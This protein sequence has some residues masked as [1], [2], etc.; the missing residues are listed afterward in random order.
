MAALRAAPRWRTTRERR[1]RAPVAR[2]TDAMRRGTG[3][4]AGKA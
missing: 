2:R 4:R 1:N 3:P